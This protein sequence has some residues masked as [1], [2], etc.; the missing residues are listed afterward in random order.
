M[1]LNTSIKI[2][3]KGAEVQRGLAKIKAGFAQLN[4]DGGKL[5]GSL[6]ANAAKFTA[7]LGPAVVGVGIAKIGLDALAAASS[8]ESLTSQFKA[9]LGSQDAAVARMSLIQQFAATTPFETSELAATSKM[10]QTLGGE[11]LS[12]GAGLRLV[13]DAAAMS[14]QP[15][16]EVGLHVGRIF[17]ALT[18]GTSAGESI[19]RLQELGLISGIA[20][21]QFEDLAEAQG[22]GKSKI[23]GSADA[24]NV[25]SQVLKK[26]QGSMVELSTTTEGRFSNLKDSYKS[27]LVELGAP[28]NTALRP[29][30]DELRAKIDELKSLASSGGSAIGA[31]LTV[32]RNSFKNGDAFE[33]IKRAFKL[34]ATVAGEKLLATFMLAGDIIGRGLKKILSG[35]SFGGIKAKFADDGSQPLTWQSAQNLAS[36]AFGSGDHRNAFTEVYNRNKTPAPQGFRFAQDGERTPFRNDVGDRLVQVLGAKLDTIAQRLAPQL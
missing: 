10:L 15:L 29:M 20:K 22:K 13:G 32:F 12:T 36:D 24:L 19:A 18:S 11:L 7:I 35:L 23:L 27:L 34:A 2:A 16:E 8:I 21:R 26:S 28:I 3:F 33:L 9:L 6:I 31:G 1:G 14:G 5:F 4:K 30:L 17:G 25:L